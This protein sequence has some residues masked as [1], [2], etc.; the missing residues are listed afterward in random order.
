M[1]IR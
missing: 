1:L